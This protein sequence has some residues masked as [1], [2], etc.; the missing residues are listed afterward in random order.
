MLVV[1]YH[2]TLDVLNH[3]IIERRQ[4][5][6]EQ[7]TFNPYNALGHLLELVES[8]I[9]R[10]NNILGYLILDDTRKELPDD[11]SSLDNIENPEYSIEDYITL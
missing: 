10:I 3:F 9:V 4:Q 1:Y 6:L 11:L 5:I 7:I 8:N 2:Y